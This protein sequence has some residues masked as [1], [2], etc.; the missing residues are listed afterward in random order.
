MRPPTFVNGGEIP[1]LL[2]LANVLTV[3]L[4]LYR[5]TS[6]EGDRNSFLGMVI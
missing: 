4:P 6:S 2:Q 3:T 1:A 5:S